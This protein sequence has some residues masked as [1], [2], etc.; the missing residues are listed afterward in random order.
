MLFFKNNAYML[1]SKGHTLYSQIKNLQEE[2][3]KIDYGNVHK[4]AS[5]KQSSASLS[6]LHFFTRYWGVSLLD[7]IACDLELREK[8][9]EGL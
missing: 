1:K 7:M 8:A 4:L 9:R 2:G 5:G 6:Y 3:L